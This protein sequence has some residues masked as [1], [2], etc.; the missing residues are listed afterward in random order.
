MDRP[1][2]IDGKCCGTCL[3]GYDIKPMNVWY[4]F[5]CSKYGD[6]V[7]QTSLCKEYEHD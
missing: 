2:L 4:G 6:E 3:F 1:Q 5:G 7:S